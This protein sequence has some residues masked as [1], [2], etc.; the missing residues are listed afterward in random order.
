MS[1]NDS[2]VTLHGDH[3]QYIIAPTQDGALQITDTVPDRDGSNVYTATQQIRFIDGN[4]VFDPTDTAENVARL[5]LGGLGRSPDLAGLINFANQVDAHISTLSNVANAMVNSP[6]FTSSYGALTDS[7]FVNRIYWNS[8]GAAPPQNAYSLLMGRLANGTSR[9]AALVSVAESIGAKVR[10]LDIAGDKNTGIVYRL[11]NA[12]LDRDPDPVGRINAV[13]NLNVGETIQQLAS[14]ILESAEY[15]A[16]AGSLSD[17]AFVSK[18]YNNLLHRDA[19]PSGLQ[20]FTSELAAGAS[21]GDVA[22]SFINGTEARAVTAQ[23]THDGWVL[24]A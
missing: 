15:Q 12:L 2:F 9:G 4:G 23:V 14:T 5:Y 18:L 21:R 16:D 6:E 20:S 7:D 8:L 1:I 3:T 22:A 13:Y 11:Y 17:S 19:D 10:S 24:A